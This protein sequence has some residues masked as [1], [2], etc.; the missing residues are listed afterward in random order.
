MKRLLVIGIVLFTLFV[1]R[2]YAA[3]SDIN[4]TIEDLKN[5][6]S[7][8]QNT[9][10]SLAKQISLINSQ[11]QLTT[12]RIT[13]IQSAIA[14]LSTEIVQLADEI[15]RLEDLLNRRSELV[16]HR[17]PESYKRK[18][19]SQFGAVFLSQNFSDFL[20]RIKY[21]EVVQKQDAQLLFQLKATQNNFSERKNL[22]E[23]KRLE[24][25]SLQ[26]ELEIQSRELERQKREKQTLLEQTR[27]D[28]SV[29][30][31]LLAGALAEKQ[32]IE[33]ALVDAVRVGP[34]KKGDPIALVGNTGYPGCST[35]AH[36]HFEVR[37]NNSWV[38]PGS[39]LSSKSVYDEQ[40]N[41]DA[42]FGSGSWDWPLEG[43]IRIT[44]RFGKTPYSWRYAY[45][46]GI[47]TGFDMTSNTS[48]VI[49]A[50]AD[51]TLYSSSQPCGGSS[52]IKIKYID[53][54]DSTLSFYL[55]VQ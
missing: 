47:H 10:N 51:G 14:K 30:Q 42:T 13:S 34:V 48:S 49:R 19:I 36:L 26:K 16:L 43:P 23:D 22:R 25:E 17:I 7:E 39:Y 21:V 27:N 1:S 9:E 44:Q 20:S 35:G 40:T 45:S 31:R 32:A 52:I 4:R 41:S 3:D 38:D 12:L 37:K 50:P 28:E 5:K 53:H 33:R 11:I 6:I 29:Y 54:G 46:G 2:V 15:E 55:H 18:V 8:L 24:Q